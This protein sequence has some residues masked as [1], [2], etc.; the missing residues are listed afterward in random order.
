MTNVSCSTNALRDVYSIYSDNFLG[1]VGGGGDAYND[2]LSRF[3]SG[4]I[5]LPV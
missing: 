4:T 1:A 2:G 5:Y 3:L